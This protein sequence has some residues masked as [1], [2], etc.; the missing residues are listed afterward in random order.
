[1]ILRDCKFVPDQE[2]VA[3]AVMSITTVVKA[4]F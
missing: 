1:M 2:N 4:H 3:A